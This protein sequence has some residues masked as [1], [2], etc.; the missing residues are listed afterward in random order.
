MPSVSSTD[1]PVAVTG[2]SGYVG[3]HT[4]IALLARGYDVRACI[5]DA[6][7]PHKTEHLLALNEQDYSGKVSLHT[8]NLLDDGSYDA[9]FAGCS[10]V[11]HVGTAMGYGGVNNPQQV[12]DGAINGT[13]NILDSIRKSGT[14]K[15][16]VYTSSF[17]AIGH[18]VPSGHIYTEQ[19]WASDNREEDANWNTDDLVRKGEV[20][21]AMAKVECEHLV[22][23]IAQ[24]DGRFDAIS[25]CP[26]VV[27]GPLLTP[28]HEL[29][30]S[31][32]YHLGRML[33][34]DECQRGWQALWNIVDVR[35]VGESQALMIE[36]DACS[37]GH[38]Y[39]LCAT[40]DRGEIS[41]KQLQ[42]HLL[43]LF[44]HIDVGG[45]PAKY[46]AMIE[47]YGKPFDAPR[48]HC[49]RARQELGLKTH[50]VRD[51]LKA[52]GETMIAL[53]LVKPKLK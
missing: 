50:D 2:A 42:E 48:A 45:P 1:G 46:D 49:D 35:D 30:G 27:L 11:L 53:G 33:A 47:K 31:W 20:G 52:T 8:A 13:T 28:V 6:G 10:A 7:N 38:R 25:V 12:Y 14:V 19:D 18:P 22:N 51:T 3:A 23:R 24:D 39:M 32:Q 41:A 40:D 21:Y 26:C 29:V 15:R 34:G 17:A 16:L 44:P 37:N 4:V 36:S 9:P 5:T 43:E